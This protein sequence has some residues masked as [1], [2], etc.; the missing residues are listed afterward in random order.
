MKIKGILFSKDACT[1]DTRNRQKYL[2]LV[3]LCDEFDLLQRPGITTEI[4]LLRLYT[5]AEYFCM[6]RKV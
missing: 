6:K 1:Q 2:Y 4:V 3:I 5:C